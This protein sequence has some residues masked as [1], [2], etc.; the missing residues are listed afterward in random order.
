MQ[1]QQP[2]N[3][4]LSLKDYLGLYSAFSPEST[5]QTAN[6]LDKFQSGQESDRVAQEHGY[7]NL[8]SLE[9]GDRV[10]QR[11]IVNQLRADQ[12]KDRTG[13]ALLEGAQAG[14]FDPQMAPYAH[15]A[16]RQYFKLMDIEPQQQQTAVDPIA[17]RM[18][19]RKKV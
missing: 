5:L 13:H 2:E 15:E 12:S 11:D 10:Q 1:Q 9:V 17:E 3:N 16:L 7:P 6:Q 8:A 19:N 14:G 4:K 18:K